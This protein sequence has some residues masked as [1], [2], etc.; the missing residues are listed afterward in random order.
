MAQITLKGNPINTVGSLPA[1]G[2]DAPGFLL[3]KTDLAD[4]RLGDYAG[5][6]VV[7]NI[8]PSVDTP[9][10]AASVRRFN[11]DLSSMDNTVVLCVSLDLPFAL[12]RFCGAEG[13]EDVVPCTELRARGFG[14]AYGCR[15]AD[16]PLAGLLS[17]AVVVIDENGKVV[18]TQQVPEIVEE[19]DYEGAMNAL[20]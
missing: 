20:K 14:E 16:G 4:V 9:I 6:K 13:L 19:P 3:T 18:Y 10:C 11:A 1:V 5:K 7:L 2:S 17:R 15:I 8:F 12:S